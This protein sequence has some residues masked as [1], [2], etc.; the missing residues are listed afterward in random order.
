MIGTEDSVITIYKIRCTRVFSMNLSSSPSSKVK[1][2]LSKYRDKIHTKNTWNTLKPVFNKKHP[3]PMDSTQT[4]KSTSELLSVSLSSK[5]WL[6][7]NPRTQVMTKEEKPKV[8]MILHLNLS[9]FYLRT[10]VSRI[11]YSTSKTSKIN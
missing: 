5:P 10:A 6:K 9:N 4:Q 1:A 2:F 11:K 7:S 3:S 8:V